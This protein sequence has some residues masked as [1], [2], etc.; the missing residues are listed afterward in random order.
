MSSGLGL[1]YSISLLYGSTFWGYSK[2]SRANF[3]YEFVGIKH[4][5]YYLPWK[6]HLQCNNVTAD[7][8]TAHKLRLRLFPHFCC[9]SLL[10]RSNLTLLWVTLLLLHTSLTESTNYHWSLSHSTTSTLL[11]SLVCSAI[12]VLHTDWCLIPFIQL[13]CLQ[14][15]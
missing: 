1:P 10:L 5:K 2:G 11:S 6:I 14:R 4:I 3:N 8:G 13:Q 12:P 15:V 9:Y 7:Q